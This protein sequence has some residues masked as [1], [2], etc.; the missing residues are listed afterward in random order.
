MTTLTY[1]GTTVVLPP[2]LLWMDEFAW[3]GVEQS[4]EYTSTGAL[5]IEEFA[6]QAG[7]PITLQGGVDYAWCLRSE[8]TTLNTWARVAGAQLTLNL[9]GVDRDV[10]WDHGGGAVR[11]DPIVPYSDPLPGDPYSLTLKFVEV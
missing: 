4:R 1:D 3:Q 8:L 7:R 2:D 6:M 10:V 5:V 11:A 9:H